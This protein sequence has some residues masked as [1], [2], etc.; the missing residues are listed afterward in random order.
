MRLANQYLLGNVQ[1]DARHICTATDLS[2]DHSLTD[3]KIVDAWKPWAVACNQNDTVTVMQ[4][5]HPGRQ[6]PAGAGKR[7]IFAKPI[8]PSA[9][10]LQ[11]GSGIIAKAVTALLFGTPREMS[12]SDIET[13]VD[14]FARSARLAAESG[15]A[16]VEIHAGHGFLLEQFMST[17]TNRRTDAYGG[18]PEKRAKIVVDIL[19]AIRNVVPAKFC[20]GLSLNSVDLQSQVELKDC[21]EQ[22]KLITA[23]GVDFIEISGGTFESPTVSVDIPNCGVAMN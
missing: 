23:V 16:G 15:F 13:V 7:G 12:I 18:T 2:V 17:K 10:S 11:M 22:V 6:S 3:E 4:L 19:R 21:I 14:Q 1:V 5:C 8:A 20:V 9:V